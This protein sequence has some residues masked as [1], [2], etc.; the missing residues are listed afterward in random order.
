MEEKKMT[1]EEMKLR[2]R[3]LMD[4]VSPSNFS[5]M[6]IVGYDDDK[7]VDAQIEQLLDASA[8]EVLLQRPLCEL[9]TTEADKSLI[10]VDAVEGCGYLPKPGDCLRLVSF[11]L[12]GWRRAV[13]HATEMDGDGA[14]RLGNRYLRGGNSRP[15]V[16]ETEGE[17]VLCP[18]DE[19]RL[20][21]DTASLRYVAVTLPED[22]PRRLQ[23][24]VCRRFVSEGEMS[25]R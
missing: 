13:C 4:E 15:V 20:K 10:R 18:C 7:P 23:E 14:M 5:A 22:L 24:V 9:P 21:G 2:I 3:T 11:R 16:V 1:R 12:P 25:Q 8:I 17:F 6:D 19:A